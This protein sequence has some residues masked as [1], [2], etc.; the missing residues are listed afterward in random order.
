MMSS[1]G[2]TNFLLK[3]YRQSSSVNGNTGVSSNSTSSSNC[4]NNNNQL[5]RR[6]GSTANLNY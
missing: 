4:N 2:S 6:S 3:H 1:S 5:G